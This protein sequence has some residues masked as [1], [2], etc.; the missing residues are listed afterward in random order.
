MEEFGVSRRRVTLD[1][2]S[3]RNDERAPWSTTTPGMGSG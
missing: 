2:D 1:L 3:L